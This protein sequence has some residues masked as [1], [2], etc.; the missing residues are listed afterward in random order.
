MAA[1]IL[2][3]TE[4]IKINLTTMNSSVVYIFVI[5]SA[6]ISKEVD[7]IHSQTSNSS[8]SIELIH[9]VIQDDLPF[10]LTLTKPL[11]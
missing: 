10:P 9:F 1:S 8:R 7:L 4:K 6:Q 5:Q 2:I 11:R 3:K